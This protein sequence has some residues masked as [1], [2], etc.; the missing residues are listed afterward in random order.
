MEQVMERFLRF[1]WI[2]PIFLN[3]VVILPLIKSQLKGLYYK[4]HGI[5]RFR[6][7]SPREASY[8][9]VKGVFLSRRMKM[10]LLFPPLPENVKLM[11]IPLHTIIFVSAMH[12]SAV[13]AA[14]CQIFLEVNEVIW[15]LGSISTFIWAGASALA[16]V[17][18]WQ[19]ER[20]WGERICVALEKR[21]KK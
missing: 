1:G 18:S 12:I 4:N 15:A 5:D 19:D 21:R 11:P 2:I 8:G 20:M 3:A 17:T 7:H 10:V 9:N 14:V 6:L 13:I 16:F